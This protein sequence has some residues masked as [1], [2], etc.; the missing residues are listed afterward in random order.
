M[1]YTH[2]FKAKYIFTVHLHFFFTTDSC[3][4][5]S[6]ALSLV[7]NNKF[8]HFSNS[9]LL[10]FSMASP[11]ISLKVYVT[12]LDLSILAEDADFFMKHVLLLWKV[13]LHFLYVPRQYV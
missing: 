11:L 6:H 8:T 4:P 9:F 1:S 2:L 5:S 3:P 13:S 12:Q 7:L 10:L